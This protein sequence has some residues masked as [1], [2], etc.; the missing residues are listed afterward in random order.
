[1]EKVEQ[2]EHKGHI[3]SLRGDAMEVTILS[4]TSC[5][6]CMVKDSCGTSEAEEKVVDVKVPVNA[7]YKIGDAVDVYYKQSLGFRA[8]LL[9]YILPFIILL[10]TLITVITITNSEGMA[11]LAA[12]LILAPYYLILYLRKDQIKDTFEFSVKKHI[13]QKPAMESVYQ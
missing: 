13:E 2:I 6:S 7:S 1:M 9:G 11:G 12:L 10:T 8:L 4:S 5:A 3:T